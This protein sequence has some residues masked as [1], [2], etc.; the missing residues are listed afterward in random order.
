MSAGGQARVCVVGA[1]MAGLACALAAAQAGAAVQVF[2]AQ[3]GLASIPAHVNVVPGML[4]GLAR[5]GVADAAVCRGFP[6]RATDVVGAD[7]RVHLKLDSQHLAGARYPAMLGIRYDDLMEV[8]QDAVRAAGVSIHFGSPLPAHAEHM[9][10]DFV[11]ADLVVL[12]TGAV[13]EATRQCFPRAPKPIEMGQLWWR[14]I[15]ARP[16]GLDAAV[17]AM[18]HEGS[19]AGVIPAGMSHAGLYLLQRDDG[20]PL[21]AAAHR[22]ERLRAALFRFKARALAQTLALLEEGSPV[23]VQRVRHALLPTPWHSGRFVTVGD[24]AHLLTPQFGQNGTQAIEDAVVLGA[25]LAQ[26]AA[27]KD[28]PA[29][30]T[31]R[32]AA[33]VGQVHEICLQVARWDLQPQPH[34]DVHALW[35]RLGEVMATEP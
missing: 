18:G 14:A 35:E 27:L 28:L 29:A 15:V 31:R 19:K 22:V 4:R 5:L 1:G 32:R 30:F 16:L 13:G 7:G 21:P 34:T 9:P 33:R 3:R 26:G 12:A 10:Q 25:L 23:L 8:L 20:E 2:E 24:A 11:D 6:Y 17:L